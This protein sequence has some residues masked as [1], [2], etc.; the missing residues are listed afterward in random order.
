MLR[1]TRVPDRKSSIAPEG[2]TH[3]FRA[4]SIVAKTP[5][6]GARGKKRVS[7]A[8]IERLGKTDE[9]LSLVMK[10]ASV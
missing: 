8:K 9:G 1:R 7:G 4:V 6:S 3:R 2:S 5:R 10:D